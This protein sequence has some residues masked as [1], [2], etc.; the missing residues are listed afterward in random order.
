[1]LERL[2]QLKFSQRRTFELAP[3]FLG[4]LGSHVIEPHAAFD[5]LETNVGRQPIL[6]A[7][8]LADESFEE[9][10]ADLSM[11][12]AW[13]DPSLIHRLADHLG[14]RPVMGPLR[15]ALEPGHSRRMIAARMPGRAGESAAPFA[16]AQ[17]DSLS[18]RP[19]QLK[20]QLRGRAEDQRLDERNLALVLA[21]PLPL[22][23]GPKLLG[24]GVRADQRVVRRDELAVGLPQP[25]PGVAEEPSWPAL[26]L[27]QEEPFRREDEEVNLVDTPVV[28]DE[29]E[30][31]PG[32]I[33]LVSRETWPARTRAPRV[34]TG[35]QI[36]RP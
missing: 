10:V 15:M 6:V 30:I 13:P 25:G 18:R 26:D 14:R 35:I 33:G 7:R 16:I 22:K 3:V 9:I 8:P 23:Q 27:D 1:M 28:G 20:L 24:L 21:G 36:P 31:A 5:V 12:L 4:R 29:F 2:E 34:P 17:T 19:L 32:A 11:P